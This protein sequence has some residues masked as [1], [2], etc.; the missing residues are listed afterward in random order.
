MADEEAGREIDRRLVAAG[1]C[2]RC[3]S[4]GMLGF[5]YP[6]VAADEVEQG[7]FYWLRQEPGGWIP[8]RGYR[9]QRGDILSLYYDDGRVEV[10]YP[11]TGCEIRGPIPEPGP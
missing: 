5:R 2:P 1:A 11:F 7:K 6:L 3:G 4:R 9:Y 10:S 8:A